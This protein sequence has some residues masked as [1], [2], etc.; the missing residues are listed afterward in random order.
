ML[1]SP[2]L[3]ALAGFLE[4]EEA[5]GRTI[6]PPRESRLRALELTALGDVRVVI[7]GQD[8]YH[9]PGQAMGLAFS[10]PCGVRIPPSLTNI[11]KELARDL[12]LPRPASGDLTPWARQGVLLLN[13][14][15]TVRAGEAGSHRGR[16]WE[17]LTDAVFAAVAARAAP[18]VFV[19]WGSAAQAKA[20]LIA[21]AGPQHRVLIA[22]H[23]SP[24]SVYRGFLGCGHFGQ[25]N[26]FLERAER[27]AINWRT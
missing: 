20:G 13:T 22:P 9:G 10:V 24:L 21:A 17:A 14:V 11:Y 2:P 26:A 6:Y 16:G 3:R 5:D 18:T 23:P 8:P 19:L 15:L 4:A 27:G 12:A 7:L 25:A 1:D